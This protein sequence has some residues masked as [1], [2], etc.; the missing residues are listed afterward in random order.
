MWAAD[1]EGAVHQP[2]TDIIWKSC[3]IWGS[4]AKS[5]TSLCTKGG[6][7]SW[8]IFLTLCLD[9]FTL[10][11]ARRLLPPSPSLSRRLCLWGSH[12]MRPMLV[13]VAS[14]PSQRL[15]SRVSTRQTHCP[16]W[17]MSMCSISRCVPLSPGGWAYVYMCYTYFTCSV[18]TVDYHRF[19]C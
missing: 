10:S 9:H 17:E 4:G 11:T 18:I 12:W 5:V 16:R 13:F 19:S 2:P 15:L 6:E 7:V 1:A 14:R 3:S 8:P